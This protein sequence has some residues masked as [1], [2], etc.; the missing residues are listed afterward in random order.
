MT[1]PSCAERLT[2]QR[3]TTNITEKLYLQKGFLA[4]NH[5]ESSF[6]SVKSSVR[7]PNLFS[8]LLNSA[9]FT[10]FAGV[11]KKHKN[12]ARQEYQMPQMSDCAYTQSIL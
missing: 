5:F 11:L 2:F 6:L 4:Q 8:P 7:W 3:A 12:H 9:K 1:N 10:H